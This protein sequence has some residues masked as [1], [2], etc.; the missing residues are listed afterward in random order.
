MRKFIYVQKSGILQV[1]VPHNYTPYTC[2]IESDDIDI[3]FP[4]EIVRENNG[5]EDFS[6][7][8]DK[9]AGEKCS[10]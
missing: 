3:K 1:Y 9:V 8:S 4:E 2:N 5:R 10:F 7:V 6:K